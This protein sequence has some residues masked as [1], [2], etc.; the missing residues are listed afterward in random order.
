MSYPV[1]SVADMTGVTIR[2]L[3]HYDEIGLLS[4]SE[5]TGAGYR[6]YSEAD[7]ERLQQIL[8]YRELGFPLAEIARILADPDP[9]GH[10]RRQHR[11]LQGRIARLRAMV[12]AIEYM[13]EV[14]QMGIQ[15]SAEERFEI[16]GGF[17][18]EQ[19]AAEA[20]RRWG[21]TDAYQASQRRATSYTKEDWQRIRGETERLYQRLAEAM[22]A[23][24]G[25]D[26]AAAMD[27]A[28]EHRGQISR[29]FYDC[30]Y[31]VHRGLGELYV[32]D[33]RFT[34]SIDGYAAG[35]AGY[36]RDAIVANAARAA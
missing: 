23:G 15:L 30:G 36:L 29:W 20:E 31:E 12:E 2:T 3:H 32:T 4:P 18:P 14:K 21:G 24:V 13:M 8:C 16:F 19:H 10:L 1:G 25:S 9:I 26:S 11:L 5:R 33:Q 27:L 6:R 7:L 22:A 17:D 28:E 34:E 35:L